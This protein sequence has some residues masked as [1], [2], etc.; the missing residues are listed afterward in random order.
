MGKYS[1]KARRLTTRDIEALKEP[2]LTHDGCGLYLQTT[3][4]PN[5]LARS[6]VFRFRLAG[7][8]RNM[9]LG[10]YPAIGIADARKLSAEARIKIQQGIDPVWDREANRIAAAARAEREAKEKIETF[11]HLA[12]EW[13]RIQESKW[14]DAHRRQVDSQMQRF[15][16]PIWNKPIRHLHEADVRAVLDPVWKE[17]S[18]T[19]SRLRQNIEGTFALAIATKR[20]DGPNP[21]RWEENLAAVFVAPSKLNVEHFK[22]V[23]FE[24]IPK[25]A[26]KLRAT[27]GAAARALEFALL[28]AIRRGKVRDARFDELTDKGTWKPPHTGKHK[29]SMEHPFEVPLPLRA[30]EIVK[31]MKRCADGDYIFGGRSDGRIGPNEIGKLMKRLAPGYDVHGLRSSF[32]DWIG[33]ETDYPRELGE[34]AMQ[35]TVGSAVENTYR[36]GNGFKKRRQLMND[37]SAFVCTPPA[38]ADGKVMPFSRKTRT[39]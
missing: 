16:A 35:H 26:A 25:F 17:K 7:I 36:H 28:T 31:E 20:Y 22:A 39:R 14:S 38:T 19:A 8:D 12:D 21:A 30:L 2:G 32:R 27:K 9:G 15:C 23:P 10:G 4:Q 29:R 3:A 1:K 6:W 33:E 5:G 13:I 37:W 34:Y 24:E 18:E 11:G